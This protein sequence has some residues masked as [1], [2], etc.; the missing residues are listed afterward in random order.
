MKNPYD[1]K[2]SPVKPVVLEDDHKETPKS[3]PEPRPVLRRAPKADP[4]IAALKQIRHL[5]EISS[6]HN[7]P[8]AQVDG[9]GW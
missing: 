2:P 6:Y 9:R 3:T 1:F 8:S 7:I 5:S 4:A